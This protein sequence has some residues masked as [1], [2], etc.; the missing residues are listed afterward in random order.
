MLYFI[1]ALIT[2]VVLQ[3]LTPADN[4]GTSYQRWVF[5]END[6]GHISNPFEMATIVSMIND[7]N[8]RPNAVCQVNRVIFRIPHPSAYLSYVTRCVK[9]SD[10]SARTMSDVINAIQNGNKTQWGNDI[11][12]RVK[13]YWATA[14]G[15]VT[16]T[17][18]Y[19]GIESAVWV[20]LINGIPTIKLDCGNPLEA[21]QNCLHAT[22]ERQI[23]LPKAI[24]KKPE[25]EIF[26]AGGI[27]EEKDD[28][29]FR[30]A[31]NIPK[32]TISL[33]IPTTEETTTK[34][35]LSTFGKIAIGVGSAVVVGT[36]T[37]LVWKNQQRK[38]TDNTANH[39][40]DPPPGNGGVDP[41]PERPIPMPNST[42]G[43]GYAIHF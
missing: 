4:S 6:P 36:I 37:Y 3:S 8:V 21:Y 2:F 11:S 28:W 14:S 5:W 20:L 18:N 9:V 32:G 13:N 29:S 33:N 16:F 27:F 26:P 42:I 43:F 34:R 31:K 41:P 38:P 24:V 12:C 40:V 25:E 15:M 17:P 23:V 35:H 10:P 39:G 7:G 1:L 22:T 30:Q 19:S